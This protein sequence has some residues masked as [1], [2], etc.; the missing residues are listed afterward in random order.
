MIVVD[1]RRLGSTPMFRAFTFTSRHARMIAVL[2]VAPVAAGQPPVEAGARSLAPGDHVSRVLLA[3]LGDARRLGQRRAAV[4]LD[5]LV[6]R[7]N[8]LRGQVQHH[9]ELL[10]AAVQAGDSQGT[11]RQRDMLVRLVARAKQLQ[12]ASENCLAQP[13]AMGTRVV[14]V[15]PVS[16]RYEPAP[17]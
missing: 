16:P 13:P 11:V 8:S 10:D 12:R 6:T 15:I 1:I 3:R 5:R 4:C 17:L 9:R 7:A 14:V 2:L